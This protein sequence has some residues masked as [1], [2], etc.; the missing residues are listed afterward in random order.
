MTLPVY[1]TRRIL[2]ADDDREVRLG[3]ADLLDQLG[4]AV[5]E[6]ETGLEAL[7]VVRQRRI[8]AAL[9]DLHMPTCTGLE[10]LPRIHQEMEGLPCIVY[11]GNLSEALER[12]LFDAGAC[13]VLRKPVDVAVLRQ[14]VLRAL[15]MS[16]Y[17]RPDGMP[18]GPAGRN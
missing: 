18:D 9:L 14:E 7:E 12:S 4:L 5:E 15:D 2:L 16:P 8:H 17:L 10:A 1:P 3:I 11:S 13:A 6:A